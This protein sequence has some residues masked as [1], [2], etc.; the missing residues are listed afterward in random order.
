MQMAACAA[1]LL[2]AARPGHLWQGDNVLKSL[3]LALQPQRPSGQPQP[4]TD[5]SSIA[6]TGLTP[7]AVG[8]PPD[9]PRAGR[10]AILATC[11]CH[12]KCT[13][14]AGAFGAHPQALCLKQLNLF[15]GGLPPSAVLPG[16]QRLQVIQQEDTLL[17]CHVEESCDDKRP[18]L[19]VTGSLWR[20]AQQLRVLV[21]HANDQKLHKCESKE[22]MK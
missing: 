3:E 8:A 12:C 9:Q 14:T 6:G 22:F 15:A 17:A 4:A 2:E 10:Y 19:P 18:N 7:R 1:E 5:F 16:H 13:F 21:K 20:C 11:C